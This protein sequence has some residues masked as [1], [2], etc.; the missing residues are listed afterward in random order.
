M[1]R[2]GLCAV[3]RGT[4]TIR[5]TSAAV[6][7]TTTIPGTGTTTTV[8]VLPVQDPARWEFQWFVA[9]GR[10]AAFVQGVVLTL[11]GSKTIRLASW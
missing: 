11:A 10:E 1:V 2:T 7:V 4:T 9:A 8:F 3:V 5:G 6:I